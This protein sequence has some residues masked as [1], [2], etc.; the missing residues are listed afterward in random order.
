MSFATG[1]AKEYVSHEEHASSVQ[2]KR[3]H[4]ISSREA[5]DITAGTS[6]DN[7]ELLAAYSSVDMN[8]LL[9]KV[10][11]GQVLQTKNLMC[12]SLVC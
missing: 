3:D 7:P 1:G 11:F 12:W 4:S 6:V 2:E 8:K 5:K 9:R 10:N